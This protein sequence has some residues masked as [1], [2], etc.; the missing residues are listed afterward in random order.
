AKDIGT[1][2]KQPADR[3][4]IRRSRSQCGNDLGTALPPH[5]VRAPG[6]APGVDPARPGGKAIAGVP[7]AGETPPGL[8]LTGPGGP[9]FGCSLDSVSCTVQARCSPV[10]TSKNPVR[11]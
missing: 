8:L 10:S 11:S 1:S 4:A 9:C 7:I 2:G 3:H 6:G 5:C